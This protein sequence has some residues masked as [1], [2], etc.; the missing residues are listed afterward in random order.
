MEWSCYAWYSTIYQEYHSHMDLTD[1]GSFACYLRQFIMDTSYQ[2]VRV[3]VNPSETPIGGT[4]SLVSSLRFSQVI[5]S[6]ASLYH[7][8][9]SEFIRYFSET[10]K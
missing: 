7:F 3:I 4:V 2:K 10:H 9:V 5:S 8:T 6:P 1:M